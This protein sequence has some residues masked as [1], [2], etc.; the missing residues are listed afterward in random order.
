MSPRIARSLFCA[1]A[2]VTAVLLGSTAAL[3]LRGMTADPPKIGDTVPDFTLAQ[4]DGKK[5]TLSAELKDGPVVLIVGRGWVGYQCPFCNR[6]FGDFLRNAKALEANGA[7]VVWVYPGPT[8]EV[9]KRAE[10]FADGKPLPS[11][12]RFVLDP[13][14][15]FT[16]AYGL[17]WDAPQETAYPSTFIIDRKRMVRYA[18]VSKAHGDRATA[19]DVL[20]VLAGMK[21]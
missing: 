3:P 9:Q 6:Q 8:E 4:I 10:E 7:R 11:N 2:V 1:A 13:A 20:A 12:F 5:L 17:R 21:K 19:A 16:L 18:S 14:Y 15:A